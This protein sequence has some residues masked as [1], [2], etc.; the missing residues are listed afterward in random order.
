MEPLIETYTYSEAGYKPCLITPD[1]QAA[2]L[3]YADSQAYSAMNKLEKHDKTDE[4]FV[5]LGGTATLIAAEFD[6]DTIVRWD[7]Q[8]LKPGVIYNI[9][10][11]GWH[12][13]A[14][15]ENAQ[16]LIV[17]DA[18]TH[19]NDVTY[20]SLTEDQQQELQTKL[21]CNGK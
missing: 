20:R 5:L 12:N 18:N 2:L 16:I 9:P 6:G 4:V 17:E 7:I 15:K 8:P 19:L 21:F 1:W 3:N 10:I 14:M 13:I 11:A